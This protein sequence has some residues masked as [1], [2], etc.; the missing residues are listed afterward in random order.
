LVGII[1]VLALLIAPAAMA[2][3]LTSNLKRRMIYSVLLGMFFCLAG[4]WL[5]YTFNFSSGAMIVILSVVCCLSAYAA[6]AMLQSK[7]KGKKTENA[8]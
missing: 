7:K 3:V 2:S 5:S 4:L 1:L 8:A 6:R